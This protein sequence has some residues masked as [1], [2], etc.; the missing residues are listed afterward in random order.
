MRDGRLNEGIEKR[1][2]PPFFKT[3]RVVDGPRRTHSIRASVL[4]RIV[5]EVDHLFASNSAQRSADALNLETR[6]DG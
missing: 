2:I 4:D 5:P 3:V 1:S 6:V